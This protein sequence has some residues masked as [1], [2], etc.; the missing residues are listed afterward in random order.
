L[1]YSEWTGK[2]TT[3]NKRAATKQR[4]PD[5]YDQNY[6]QIKVNAFQE[7]CFSDHTESKKN[8]D[9]TIEPLN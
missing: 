9:Q 8:V 1:N 5:P 4:V 7:E 3:L 2:R 6:G